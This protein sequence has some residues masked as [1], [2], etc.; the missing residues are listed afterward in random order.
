[1]GMSASQVN[2]VAANYGVN[3]RFSGNTQGA[4]AKSIKQSLAPETLV[5]PGTIID[6][7]FVTSANAD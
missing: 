5:S 1:M 7:E 2:Q 4:Q 3:V 6:V